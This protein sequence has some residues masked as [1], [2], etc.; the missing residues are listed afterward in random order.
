MSRLSRRCGNLDLS[1]PYGPSR[2]PLMCFYLVVVVG[3]ACIND[4]EN[5]VGGSVANGRVSQVEQ[6]EVCVPDEMKPTHVLRR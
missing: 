1:H 4:T 5:Y 3:L 2:P 6:V